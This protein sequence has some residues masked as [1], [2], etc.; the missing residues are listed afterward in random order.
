MILDYAKSKP[1]ETITHHTN[2]VLNELVILKKLY[3]KKKLK[4]L[5]MLNQ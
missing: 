3:G 4:E 1:I 5:K 2:E